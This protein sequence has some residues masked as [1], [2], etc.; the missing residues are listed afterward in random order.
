[1]KKLAISFIIAVLLMT[2]AAIGFQVIAEVWDSEFM[3][4]APLVM[5]FFI[6]LMGWSCK[7][8]ADYLLSPGK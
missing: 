2:F 1:M 8:L 6:V 7:R 3:L 4:A 5:A